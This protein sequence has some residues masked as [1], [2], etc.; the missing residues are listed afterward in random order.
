ML[1]KG[2]AGASKAVTAVCEE[3]FVIGN[4]CL[5]ASSFAILDDT[6]KTAELAVKFVASLLGHQIL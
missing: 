3:N 4:H 1:P 6:N 2:K 5:D